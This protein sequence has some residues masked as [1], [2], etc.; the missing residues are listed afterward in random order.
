MSCTQHVRRRPLSQLLADRNVRHADHVPVVEQKNLP[1]KG[2]A[3][4]S[5]IFYQR[6]NK[7]KAI[8]ILSN[9]NQ[10]QL[11][12]NQPNQFNSI[13]PIISNSRCRGINQSIAKHYPK[14]K[15][16]KKIKYQTTQRSRQ[17]V[18]LRLRQRLRGCRNWRRGKGAAGLCKHRG[19]GARG[20]FK[21][22]RRKINNKI[23]KKNQFKKKKKK[24]SKKKKKK[25]SKSARHNHPTGEGFL[26][27]KISAFHCSEIGTEESGSKC[28]GFRIR[29]ERN[30]KKKIEEQKKEKRKKKGKYGVMGRMVF[31]PKITVPESRGEKKR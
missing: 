3:F 9:Q 27:K 22:E 24:K 13:Q 10:Y 16:Q 30:K 2:V 17:L 12:D 28:I 25:V 1:Q 23:S 31:S 7:K 18:L 15:N 8:I 26:I 6:K 14:K 21:K 4:V 20:P 29:M 19:L 11:Q 5:T